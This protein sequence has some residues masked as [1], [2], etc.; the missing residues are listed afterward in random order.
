MENISGSIDLLKLAGA[1]IVN[2]KNGVPHLVVPID[3][4]KLQTYSKDGGSQKIFL[5]LT[6]KYKE[7][8]QYG[9][10]FM[11]SRSTTKEESEF[12]KTAQKEDKKYGEILGNAKFFANPQ[13][14]PTQP[15]VT[16]SFEPDDSG[17][18][19]PF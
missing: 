5:N 2:G 1:K 11:V 19:L 4:A 7:N 12:N 16:G 8:D 18:D 10:D 13:S 3:E 14:G 17:N 6:L 15:E 9:N